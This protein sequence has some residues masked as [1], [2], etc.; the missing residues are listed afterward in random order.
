MDSNPFRSKRNRNYNKNSNNDKFSWT[1]SFVLLTSIISVR[2]TVAECPRLCECKWKSGKESVLCLNANLTGVPSELDAGTQV[3]DLTGNEISS[4]PQDTFRSANLINLQRVFIAKC[5]LKSIERYAFRKLINL[6]E[7]DL[8]YNMLTAIPSHAFDSTPELRELKIVANPITRISNE[9]F[10]HVPQLVRLELS[11][12]RIAELEAR[13]FAGLE[14]S[15]EWLKLDGNR[16]AEVNAATL[17]SLQNLHGLELSGNPWNCSCSLR[18]LRE[19]M[20]KDNIPYDVPPICKNPTRLT[21][22]S[23]DKI[24]LDDFACVPHILASDIKAH[25]MEGRNITMSC[26]VGGIPEPNVR[27]MLRNRVIANLTGNSALPAAQGRKMYLANLQQNES[28]LTILTA[29]VQDAGIYTCAAENKAGLVEASVTLAISRKPLEG[30]FGAKVLIA[31]VVV[32]ALFVIASS[33][34]VVCVCTLHKR[35]KMGRWNTPRRTESYE[36]IEMNHKPMAGRGYKSPRNDV[37][38]FM[39]PYGENGISVVGQN[40]RRNGDYRTVPSEDDGTGYEDNI[41]ESTNTTLSNTRREHAA[42]RKG[43]SALT[44]SPNC[45]TWVEGNLKNSPRGEETDLHI[46]RLIEFSDATPD[47]GPNSLT[48]QHDQ[49]PRTS[50]SSSMNSTLPITSYIKPNWSQH[51]I[52]KQTSGNNNNGNNVYTSDSSG[53][54]TKSPLNDNS[55]PNIEC[56]N[57]RKYPDLLDISSLSNSNVASANVKTSTS[58]ASFSTLPRK[59]RNTGRYMK[60]VSDSQSPLLQESSSRYGSSN[61]FGDSTDHINRRLSVDSYSNNYS[62][63]NNDPNRANSFLNLVSPMNGKHH[64][65]NPSLPSSPLKESHKTFSPAAT[66]LLDFSSLQSR[67]AIITTPSPSTSTTTASAYDYHAAQLERFLEEYRNLQEQLCKMKET[68]DSIRKKEQ[69]HRST[70]GQSAKFAD[71]VMY[72][73]AALSSAGGTLTDEANTNP[74]G[75][76]R[77]KTFIPGQPPDPPP[78]WLHRNAILKRLQDPSNEFFQ[79]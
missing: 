73:A 49:I 31:G 66:P 33:L 50:A 22:K 63:N 32:A 21:T 35:R 58:G 62:S 7:V 40:V 44:K 20:I 46:P 6:V 12:C 16:L 53:Q 52:R 4:I 27:W 77:N 24:D 75:I 38:N 42:K 39:K 13:A 51:I 61:F 9:A 2:S 19:W 28:N 36:K 48:G 47:S 70:L 71:P 8:S 29:E 55:S 60:V 1:I 57:D 43:T 79:S 74:K 41:C 15:L 18:P 17:T 78:Y 69:P 26:V 45:D 68:C 34:A 25:G 14:A 30:Q 67:N 3:L 5:R 72:A 10:I 65:R 23:W 37:N 56:D 54:P 11:N 59:K 76:I 64:R